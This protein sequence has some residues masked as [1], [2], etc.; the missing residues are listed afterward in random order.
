MLK[1]GLGSMMKKAQEMQENMQR[2]QEELGNKTVTGQAGAGAVEVVMNGHF[3]CERVIFS[4]ELLSEDKEMIEALI[5]AAV[6]DAAKKAQAM[7]QKEM[8]AI[9]GGMNLPP[10]FKMPF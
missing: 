10:G 3:G 6:S 9:T 7:S 8:A 4:D 2:I 1:G 5:A